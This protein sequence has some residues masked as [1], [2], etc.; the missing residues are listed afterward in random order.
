MV[1]GSGAA[2]IS[3]ALTADAAGLR[4]LIVTKDLIG[5]ATPLAQGGL[6]AAIGP[7]DSAASHVSDTL[8]AGAGLCEP[9]VVAA[10]ADAAPGAIDWLAALGARL[11]T[12]ELRLEG[13]H[14]HHRI[15]H[16]GDDASGAEVHRALLAALHASGIEILDRTVA[17]DLRF[18][19][20]EEVA[21]SA[22][23]A[24]GARR[25]D[26]A[27]GGSDRNRR[28]AVGR[29]HRRGGRGDRGRG[30]GAGVRDD[31]ESGRGDR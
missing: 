24:G 23:M 4:V 25:A 27:G 11:D 30:A 19:H 8:T 10:L 12:R 14:S 18:G 6:A 7:G 15:V 29:G 17:L 1:V 28:A 16:S 22:G 2:G 21:G 20:T 5:G 9:D 3:A 31:V 13:G 26:G